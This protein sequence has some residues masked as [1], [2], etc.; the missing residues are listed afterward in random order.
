MGDRFVQLCRH[1][2]PWRETDTAAKFAR[3]VRLICEPGSQGGLDNRM[4]RSQ[5]ALRPRDTQLFEISVGWKADVLPEG[6]D[7]MVGTQADSIR[8]LLKRDPQGGIIM[9]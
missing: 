2:S 4:T 1:A 7:E 8:Q 3:Q 6:P 9:K 5:Q